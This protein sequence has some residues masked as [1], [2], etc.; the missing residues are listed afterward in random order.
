MA[1]RFKAKKKARDAAKQ[2]QL[3]SRQEARKRG[4]RVLPSNK[5]AGHEQETFVPRI[6]RRSKRAPDKTGNIFERLY[7][8]GAAR[9][10]ARHLRTAAANA[11]ARGETR[12]AQQMLD[13]ASSPMQVMRGNMDTDSIDT[14]V[15]Q[16]SPG[17]DKGVHR[18]HPRTSA[19]AATKHQFNEVVFDMDKHSFILARLEV[20]A[21]ANAVPPANSE[22]MY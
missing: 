21:R 7:K 22:D 6:N 1:R 4:E 15:L 12:R 18:S 10:L 17:S 11:N 5:D 19:L 13:M 2:R 3:Q 20:Q 9:H 14:S 16:W 8:E